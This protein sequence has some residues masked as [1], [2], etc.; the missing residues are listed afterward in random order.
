MLLQL[1]HHVLHSQ[2]VVLSQHILLPNLLLPYT[3][4]LALTIYQVLEHVPLVLH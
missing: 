4:V 2:K 3:L 1:V